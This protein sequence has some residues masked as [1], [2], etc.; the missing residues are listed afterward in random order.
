LAFLLNCR[1]DTSLDATDQDKIADFVWANRIRREVVVLC[2]QELKAIQD[3]DER[4]APEVDEIKQEQ[5]TRDREQKFWS[6]AT[7]AE[8]HFGLGE[9]EQYKR[10]REDAA[11]MKTAHWMMDTFDIQITKLRPLLEKHGHLLNPPW[12]ER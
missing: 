6:L 10:T 4:R 3:R 8:A 1:T 7:K 11:A 9:F 2:E 5:T 12:R